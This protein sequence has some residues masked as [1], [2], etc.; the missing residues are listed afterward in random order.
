MI[1]ASNTNDIADL[2]LI[3]CYYNS[4]FHLKCSCLLKLLVRYYSDR[5]SIYNNIRNDKYQLEIQV[6]LGMLLC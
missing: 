1:R 5:I 3:H 2:V 4:G 6:F